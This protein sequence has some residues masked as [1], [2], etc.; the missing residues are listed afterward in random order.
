MDYNASECASLQNNALHRFTKISEYCDIT[1]LPAYKIYI[2]AMQHFP[3]VFPL[4]YFVL[5]LFS[6]GPFPLY[7]VP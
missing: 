5:L 3:F 7:R 4:S 2:G 6:S 1:I